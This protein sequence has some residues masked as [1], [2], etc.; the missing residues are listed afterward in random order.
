MN[1]IVLH[2]NVNIIIITVPVASMF[3]L[4]AYLTCLNKWIITALSM[5]CNRRKEQV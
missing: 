3:V 1:F 5:T 4:N 2:I